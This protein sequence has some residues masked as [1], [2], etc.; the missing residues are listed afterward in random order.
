MSDANGGEFYN[1]CIQRRST[2]GILCAC[3]FL[4]KYLLKYCKPTIQRKPYVLLQISEKLKDGIDE[5]TLWL[6]YEI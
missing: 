3:V 1:P 2:Y 4:G 5:N 6:R